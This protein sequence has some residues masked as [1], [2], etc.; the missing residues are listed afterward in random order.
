MRS[1]PSLL[2]C[3]ITSALL[4]GGCASTPQD[5]ISQNRALYESFPAEVQRK[6]SAGQVDVGFTP[7]MVILALGKPE[8]KLTRAEA[9][10]E[11][12]V[13]VYIKSK[14]QFSF[15]VG[16]GGGSYSG[17][18]YSGGGVG[19]STSTLP[20][21]EYMRVVFVGGKVSAIEKNVNG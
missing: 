2:L 21:D 3:V 10:G 13:W 5:R 15:G 7:D 14:P 17:G 16:V 11:S 18:G 12:E 1:S 9:G 20:N 4:L 8:R 19:V 6:V